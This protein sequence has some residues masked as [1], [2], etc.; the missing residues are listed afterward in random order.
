MTETL[1]DI[2][3]ESTIP[4]KELVLPDLNGTQR[5]NNQQRTQLLLKKALDLYSTYSHPRGILRE[6]TVNE[7]GEIY[8][9]EGRN[10]NETPVENIYPLAE[11]LALF[12]VTIGGKACRKISDLFQSNDFAL[13]Y[14]LDAVGSAAVEKAADYLQRHYFDRLVDSGQIA[15]TSGIQRYSPGYCGWHISGQRKLFAYLHP[16]KIGISLN[17][18]Y[19][20]LP[21][22]SISGVFVIGPE[23]IFDISGE[24]PVCAGCSEPSCRDRDGLSPRTKMNNREDKYGDS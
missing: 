16:E 8:S 13:G 5:A 23:K 12:A 7:F 11:N 14:L 17:A 9:G 22:K 1:I 21:L 24:F 10:E 2:P 3:L 4:D 19:L 20:M 18:S 6:T 15:A